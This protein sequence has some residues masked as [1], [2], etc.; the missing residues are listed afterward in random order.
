MCVMILQMSINCGVV[1]QV[2]VSIL[3]VSVNVEQARALTLP[4]EATTVGRAPCVITTVRPLAPFSFGI[5]AICSTL[6]DMTDA[7]QKCTFRAAPSHAT[8]LC[9]EA[10]QWQ[11]D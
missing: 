1:L 5:L 3:Q 8:A 4:W 9:A 11:H 6:L 2:S 10:W 7:Q